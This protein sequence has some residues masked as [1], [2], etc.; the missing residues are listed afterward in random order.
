MF[1]YTDEFPSGQG[2]SHQLLLSIGGLIGDAIISHRRDEELLAKN[3]ELDELNQ[4]N[5]PN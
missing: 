5:T 2:I 4:L 1:L 3:Y